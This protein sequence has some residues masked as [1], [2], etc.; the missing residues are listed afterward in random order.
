[1]KKLLAALLAAVMALSLCGC[2]AQEEPLTPERTPTP[3]P[4]RQEVWAAEPP[5]F[6]LGNEDGNIAAGGYTVMDQ[7]RT[8]GED[9]KWHY[10]RT[11]YA[12]LA[13]GIYRGKGYEQGVFE[14][15]C[16]DKASCLNL[17][18]GRLYYINTFEKEGTLHEEI[19]SVNTDGQD[20]KV[21][22]DA[23]PVEEKQ[24][25]ED[26]FPYGVNCT[27]RSGYTD[28]YLG[29]NVLYYIADTD[30][31]GGAHISTRESGSC[32]VRWESG[33]A[34]FALDLATGQRQV[35]DGEMGNGACRMILENGGGVGTMIYT[36]AYDGGSEGAL[37]TVIQ[38]LYP[39]ESGNEASPEIYMISSEEIV[40]LT[41]DDYFIGRGTEEN[42]ALRIEC[43]YTN[44]SDPPWENMPDIA[45]PLITDDEIYWIS[46]DK[47]EEGWENV[48]L[49]HSRK[50]G[51]R[52][53]HDPI[54]EIGNITAE[55]ELSQFSLSC[56]GGIYLRTEDALYAVQAY[57]DSGPKEIVK[58]IDN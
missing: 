22:T 44:E 42:D 14:R 29:E 58:L 45:Q 30:M 7:V 28:L 4:V 27:M 46:G 10:D 16:T 49:M 15:I 41:E 18:E 31:G 11:V 13:D 23:L 36:E 55:H 17:W 21:H 52:M 47:T 43:F 12:A 26:Q 1:M 40:G 37:Q 53:R 34:L 3:E 50:D 20:R 9:G 56:H 32:W 54:A 2:M 25:I 8:K 48:M 57:G 33:P 38:W 35:M 51:S 19:V 6:R 39:V 24:I 5:Q